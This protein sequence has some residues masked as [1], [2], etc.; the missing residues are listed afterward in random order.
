MWSIA[1]RYY[2]SG[3]EFDRVVDAN[4]GRPQVAYRET[5]KKRVEKVEGK[6]IRQSGGKGQYGHVVINIE[7]AKQGEGFIFEDVGFSYPDG[8]AVLHGTATVTGLGSGTNLP[9][10]FEAHAGGPG[11]TATLTVSGLTFHE[12]LLEGQVTIH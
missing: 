10:T 4:I 2:G 12:I 9:F 8:T 7:P 11:T 3:E 6:F 5:I 1:A